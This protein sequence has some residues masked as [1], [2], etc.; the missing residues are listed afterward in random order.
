MGRE[1][2]DTLSKDDWVTMSPGS[3][4][5]ASLASMA[6]VQL[7]HDPSLLKLCWL[8]LLAEPGHAIYKRDDPQGTCA[9]VLRS[10]LFGVV[11]WPMRPRKVHY[12]GCGPLK[13]FELVLDGSVKKCGFVC[14]TP[15][16]YEELEGWVMHK[17]VPASPLTIGAKLPVTL[18]PAG[19]VLTHGGSNTLLRMAG[20]SGFKLLNAHMLG[21][22]FTFLKVPYEGRRPQQAEAL[23]ASILRWLFP[24]WTDEAIDAKVQHRSSSDEQVPA[25]SVDSDEK[26]DL[27]EEFLEPDEVQTIRKLVAKR[28]RH[29]RRFFLG[30]CIRIDQIA[31]LGGV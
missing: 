13:Y 17:C 30:L 12:D 10:T 18:R 27:T 24:K 16:D 14:L 7:R 1:T 20:E 19:C 15:K 11:T 9:L 4:A 25:T 3:F 6:V 2:L 23:A 8:S 28:K 22:L 21:K 5:L 29:H 31:E 26:V